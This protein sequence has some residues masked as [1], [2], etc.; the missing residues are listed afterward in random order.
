VI[1]ESLG[2]STN[3]PADAALDL[4]GDGMSN[5]AEYI[6]GT[7]PANKL[8]YLKIDSITAGGR[9]TLTFG[10]VSNKTYSVEYTDTLGT[11]PWLRLTNLIARPAD[12]VETVF[13][14]GFTTNRAYRLVTPQQP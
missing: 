5:Y 4:D 2:L 8:S 13:D 10:A 9:A 3:N 1:E 12:H 6:A 14:T 11:S 7:D